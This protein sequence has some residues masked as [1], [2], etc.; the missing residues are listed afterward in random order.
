MRPKG[1]F[2]SHADL[3][4]S[5]EDRKLLIERVS[6]SRYLNRSARLRDLLLYLTTRVLEEDAF[7]IH[8]QEVGHQVFG[9][10]ANYDTT[11]DNIVRVHA[12]MLRK[13]L[14]QY[15]EEAGAGEP[16]VIEIPKGNYAPVFRPRTTATLV[17]ARPDVPAKPR[18][19][20]GLTW[21]LAALAVLFAAS[22]AYLMW[23][24]AAPVSG[25]T[26]APQI[27]RLFWSQLFRPG[28]PTDIVVDDSSIGIYQD[29]T[30][31][32]VKLAEYFDRDYLR[33]V[34]R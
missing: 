17:E 6:S 24:P 19:L 28:T 7:E 25:R 30:G 2:M 20:N 26:E 4:N 12:S 1:A 5:A 21:T 29:M 32:A 14:E 27:V 33:S 15:F 10:P 31:R 18:R 22:T 3:L 34:G 11:S 23:R 8:E 13:R 9:R 16:I